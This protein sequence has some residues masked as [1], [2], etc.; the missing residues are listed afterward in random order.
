MASL[1]IALAV[2]LAEAKSKSEVRTVT[3]CLSHGEKASQFTL[4]ADDG[5]AWQLRSPKV[6][7]ARHVG[8]TITAT[9]VVAHAKLHNL[10]ESTKD[11]AKVTG[12]KKDISE[13]GRLIVTNIKMI[14]ESC[15]K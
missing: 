12:A 5:S 4:E 10:K 14:A 3:G 9:G 8:H 2:P 11:A 6:R 13:H 15:K 1:C 7:L